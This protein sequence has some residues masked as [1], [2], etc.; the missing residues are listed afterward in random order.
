MTIPV[1]E[2]LV[3]RNEELQWGH[4]LA[5][6][7]VPAPAFAANPGCGEALAAGQK[8]PALLCS[9]KALNMQ[10]ST[11]SFR[12]HR[13]LLDLGG[14][15]ELSVLRPRN[16][17]AVTSSKK[18][19]KKVQVSGTRARDLLMAPWYLSERCPRPEGL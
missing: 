18:L 13:R 2:L 14:T 12:I 19:P 1:L 6:G 17:A 5:V 10:E 8:H 7:L 3:R 15:W 16:P 9:G 11:H 4:I